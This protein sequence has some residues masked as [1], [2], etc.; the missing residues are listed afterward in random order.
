VNTDDDLTNFSRS[1]LHG[2]LK[3][4]VLKSAEINSQWALIEKGEID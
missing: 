2:L 3:V 4:M 1:N